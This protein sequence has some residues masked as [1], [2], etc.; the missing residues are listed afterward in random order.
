MQW[1]PT[2]TLSFPSASHLLVSVKRGLRFGFALLVFSANGF[3]Q[4]AEAEPE[5][6]VKDPFDR[7]ADFIGYLLDEGLFEYAN[8]AVEEARGNFPGLTDRI[9]VVEVG[10]LLR[11]G[12]TKEVEAILADKNLANDMKGQAMLLQL[13]MTYDAMSKNEEAMIRYQQF[14]KLNEGKEI[15]DPDVLRYFASAGLRLATILQSEE[16]YEDAGKVLN[17]V[18]KTSDDKYLK[19]K[20]TLIAAQNRLDQ[21]L[22]QNGKNRETSLAAAGEYANELLWGGNDNYFYMAMG[23]KAWLE[24]VNNKT[25]EAVSSLNEV[26]TKAIAVEKSLDEVEAPKSEYPR[27]LLRYVEGQ[28][29]W[30]KAKTAMQNGDEAGAKKLAVQAAGNLYNAF[31]RYEGNVYADRAALAFEDLKVW[32]KDTFGTE[33][34]MG[35]PSPRVAELMFN[36]Q[37]D[38]AKKLQQENQ[39]DAA[40]DKLLQGLLAYPDTKYTLTA[41]DTLSRIWIQMNHD[42]ELMAL[43]SQVAEVYSDN[44]TGSRILLR[45]GKKM[46]DDENLIGV[47]KVLGDFGRNF[48]SH[49]SAPGMLFKIGSAASERGE[50]G[51]ALGVYEDILELYPESN[52]AVRVLQLRA[53][54]ALKSEN[55]EEAIKAFEQVRDQAR[56]PLQVAFA[57]LR[58]ADTKLSATD[59]EMEKEAIQELMALRVELEKPGTVFYEEANREQTVEFLKN[60]RYRIGQVLLRQASRDKD[61]KLRAQAANELNSFLQEFPDTEQAPDVMYNLGRLYLQQGQFDQ[62]TKTFETLSNKYPESE[63]GKDALYSLVKASLE[64][65]QVQVAQEAVQKMIAQPDNYEIEKIYQVAQLMLENER[66]NEAKDSFKLVLASPR[67]QDN[68]SMRQ[69]ALNGMGE[70]SLGAGDLDAAEQSF[71]S[72]ID[73]FPTSSMVLKAGISLADVYLEKDPPD[74]AKAR[75]ALGAVARV[76]RSLNPPNKV[77]KAHLDL[78]LGHVSMAEGNPGAALANWYGVGLTLPDSE[79]LGALVREALQLSI[80]QA[81]IEIEA[82]NRN[83]WNLI[84]E[85]TNQYLKNFPMGKDAGEMRILNNRAIGEAPEE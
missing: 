79:E 84:I 26:K 83:R 16:K 11:Q 58:I 5:T 36:R 1:I 68:P 76:V 75:L 77:A 15:S 13:A 80:A 50:Q 31:L 78:M 41:L 17:L 39:L 4:D 64:E 71:Q 33:L 47:E 74:P 61:D 12:K 35:E 73:D 40:E 2:S 19:R 34:K 44:E 49:P 69:R 10:T 3:A 66:W 38:L 59:L 6:R 57:Q 22:T 29:Q 63:A 20:F 82:G 25:D 43:S 7:E 8:L 70:S 45:I 54:E 24:F 28:V 51:L 46:A 52:Y 60:V 18:I 53:E 9:Q 55:Y 56:D 62:A 23:I 32:I 81:Q 85:L 48:P 72:L 37:L 30:A 21:G 65:G 14:L 27:A 42:W 67:S